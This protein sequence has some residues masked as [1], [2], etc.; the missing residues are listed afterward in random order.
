MIRAEGKW[1]K[2]IRKW[3]VIRRTLLS[4]CFY[5]AQFK[6]GLWIFAE[7]HDVGSAHLSAD[8][9]DQWIKHQCAPPVAPI[10]SVVI[11]YP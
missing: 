9:A 3:R 8:S 1:P 2:D 5:V 6:R 4:K 10:E 11:T 7:W